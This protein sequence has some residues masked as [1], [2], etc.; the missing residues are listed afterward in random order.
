MFT[1]RAEHRLAAAHRQCGRA[2]DAASAALWGWWTMSGGRDSRR[3]AERLERNRARAA[4]A[5]R[6]H[7][8]RV[9]A[10]AQAM[11]APAGDARR[12][13][14]G[15]VS[16]WKPPPGDEHLDEATFV[17]ELQVPRVRASATTTSGRARCAG[18]PRAFPRA[19]AYAGI[20]GLSR[21][22]VER[23]SAVGPTRSVR[24]S[25]VPGV[26]PAAVAILAS[27]LARRVKWLWC[28]RTPSANRAMPKRSALA[29]RRALQL[30]R[31]NRL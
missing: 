9:D 8:R 18:A 26:T 5:A 15:W 4:S 21:E 23:L 11:G 20:P 29:V 25:R 12:C 17:A 28:L 14:G 6:A 16:L 2:P 19:F 31:C 30:A 7:R 22:V 24:P 10:V 1:S 13:R 3:G 27:R